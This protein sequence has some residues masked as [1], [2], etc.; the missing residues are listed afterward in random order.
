MGSLSPVN[1]R[2]DESDY[3]MRYVSLKFSHP[4]LPDAHATFFEWD[5]ADHPVIGEDFLDVA[6]SRSQE[7]YDMAAVVQQCWSDEYEH[8]LDYGSVVVF[9]RLVVS[10]PMPG[11]WPTA[12]AAIKR[13]FS[14]R[15]SMMLLKAFPLEWENR[16]QDPQAPGSIDFDR[17]LTAMMKHYQRQLGVSRLPVSST[18]G[19]WMWLPIRFD[20]C[21]PHTGADRTPGKFL[22]ELENPCGAISVHLRFRFDGSE[23]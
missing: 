23:R 22:S 5:A 13:E 6:D 21:R 7:D 2:V 12:R 17:R 15:A 14:R 11:F 1:F 18:Y 3:K 4:N 20:E 10:Q 8:P 9:H 19:Q 16:F